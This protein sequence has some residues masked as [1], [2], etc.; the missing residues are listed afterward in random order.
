[1]LGKPNVK[2]HSDE[3]EKIKVFEAF[4]IWTVN[5]K[6]DKKESYIIS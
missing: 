5:N 1:M 2:L 3:N 4:N 6:P